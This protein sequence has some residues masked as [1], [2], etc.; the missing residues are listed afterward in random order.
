VRGWL[1]GDRTLRLLQKFLLKILW[2]TLSPTIGVHTLTHGRTGRTLPLVSSRTTELHPYFEPE[3]LAQVHALDCERHR[4]T[5]I[6][7]CLDELIAED[8]QQDLSEVVQAI[9]RVC[10]VLQQVREDVRQV[11]QRVTRLAEILAGEN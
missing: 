9:G 6:D 4:A 8:R 1:H 3:I 7:E 11:D 10:T 2:C 5:T